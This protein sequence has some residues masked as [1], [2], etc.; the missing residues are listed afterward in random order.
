MPEIDPKW[1]FSGVSGSQGPQGCSCWSKMVPGHWYTVP[2]YATALP[3][4]IVDFKIPNLAKI[5]PEMA[6]K[7]SFW[8]VFW[9]FLAPRGP[10]GVQVG[11]RWW[12][13]TG[14]L[15]HTMPQPSQVPLWA[16]KSQIW[17]KKLA[18]SGPNMLILGVSVSLGPQGCSSWSTMVA[19]HWYT[20][21]LYTTALPGSIVG[22][23][24]PTLAKIWPEMPLKCSL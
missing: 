20:V 15:S 7:C 10:R 8:V 4:S 18:R 14:I 23:K 21:P 12:Q 17:A 16:L 11:P 22:F 1:L 19:G 9:G 13:D 3:G 5:W 24:I 2:H 6:Q